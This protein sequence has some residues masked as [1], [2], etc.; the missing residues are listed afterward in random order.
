ML[1]LAIGV[2][3]AV[4][5]VIALHQRDCQRDRVG[6]PHSERAARFRI[7]QVNLR[8]AWAAIAGVFLLVIPFGLPDEPFSKRAIMVGVGAALLLLAG[9]LGSAGLR[10]NLPRR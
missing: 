3:I 1:A 2:G 4:I 7:L 6:M 10:K 8:V 9:W 5:S